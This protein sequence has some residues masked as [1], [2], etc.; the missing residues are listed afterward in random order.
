MPRTED[1]RL[2]TGGGRYVSDL[3]RP[4][5]LHVAFVRSVHAHAR[6]RGL[7]VAAA[8]SAA[9]VVATVTGADERFV[10]L[11]IRARSALPTYVPTE[12]PILAWPEI[13][14]AGEAVAA[15]VAVDRYRA[16]D[17]AA[18]VAVDYEPLPAAV[19][20]A[21]APGAAAPRVHEAAPDNVLLTR[22]FE[23]GGVDAALA[24]AAVVIERT[25]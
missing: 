11:R 17:A 6:I 22:R 3:E 8:A 14:F 2:V 20:V 4:R 25:F 21:P 15:V 9:G 19:D 5:M 23:S 24:G 13:R 10:G 16:E 7:D 12:Q 1:A 18:L